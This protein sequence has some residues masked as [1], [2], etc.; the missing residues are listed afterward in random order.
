MTAPLREGSRGPEVLELQ[1][2]LRATGHDPGPLD[3]IFGPRTREAYLRAFVARWG[4]PGDTLVESVVDEI[5]DEDMGMLRALPRVAVEMPRLHT[6]TTLAALSEALTFGCVTA[7]GH[8]AYAPDPRQLSAAIRVALAQLAVEHGADYS[9]LW[10]NDVGNRQVGAED[11]AFAQSGPEAPLV[12]HF[13]MTPLEGSGSGAK[14]IHSPHYA[15]PPGPTGLEEG[16]AA[17]WRF[18]RDHCAPALAAFEAGDPA[19]AA[20]ELKIGA[21]RYTGDEADYARAMVDRFS[22]LP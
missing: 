6:P 7:L 18:L 2:L 19:A 1:W 5:D 22:R 17:Y 14:K 8:P 9:A 3:G 15:Y 20:H 4:Q 11:R 16:A 12:P 21:W 10:S 13:Y